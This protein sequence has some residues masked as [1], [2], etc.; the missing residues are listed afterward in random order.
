MPAIDIARLAHLILRSYS[1]EDVIDEY[2]QS[3][4]G[5]SFLSLPVDEAMKDGGWKVLFFELRTSTDLD[6]M[7]SADFYTLHRH[8]AKFLGTEWQ[9]RFPPG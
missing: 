7:E 8:V 1:E 6:R 2:G 4:D 3:S 9:K 5:R